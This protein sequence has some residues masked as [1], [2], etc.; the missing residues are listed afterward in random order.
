M[1]VLT[2]FPERLQPGTVIYLGER[3]KPHT[4]RSRRSHQAL[5]LVAFEG[6]PDRTAV[7][8]LRNQVV[9]LP[10]DQAPELP[11]GEFYRFELL[12]LNVFDE[13]GQNLGVVEEVLETGANDV[14]L[15]RMANGTELLLPLI[16][17]VVKKIE[18]DLGSIHIFLMPGLL[19][20]AG[21]EA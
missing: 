14:L 17:E 7:E 19:P 1:L 2:D 5:L 13:K 16:D 6:Y 21:E 20:G 12:N 15:V 3:Y 4:I 10:A 9:Y 8:V 11:A 18:P